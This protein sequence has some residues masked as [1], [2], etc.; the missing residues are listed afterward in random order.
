M[1][2]VTIAGNGETLTAGELK[3]MLKDEIDETPIY[4]FCASTG[5]T[6]AITS[7]SYGKFIN[8]NPHEDG[9]AE[10]IATESLRY[11]LQKRE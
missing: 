8:G 9:Y 2:F 7:G 10:L 4:M 3:E 5:H 1:S 11:P 6:Y